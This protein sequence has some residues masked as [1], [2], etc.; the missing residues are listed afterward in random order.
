MS[1][2]NDVEFSLA[3]A[4]TA[5]F[6]V[7]LETD[8]LVPVPVD[9]SGYTA[10]M[11]VLKY[12]GSEFGSQQLALTSGGGGIV[13]GT[14]DGLFT[15]SFTVANTNALATAFGSPPPREPARFRFFV[16]PPSLPEIEI[17]HGSIV[18][19]ESGAVV[20]PVSSS[21]RTGAFTVEA[22][23]SIP[24]G[25][26]QL[27]VPTGQ[28]IDANETLHYGTKPQWYFNGTRTANRSK[29]AG[30]T[31][32]GPIPGKVM[33]FIV[34]GTGA[35]TVAIL[36]GGLSAGT[37]WT[38]PASTKQMVS[39]RDDGVDWVLGGVQEVALG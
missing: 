38:V 9:V 32:V 2:P 11:Q 31:G 10:R 37:I 15:A 5:T 1:E 8:S 30:R 39:V 35:F 3:Y 14:V 18:L 26:E 36:N 23:L 34:G 4:G 27:A 28:M 17:V 33:T 7:T 22:S 19:L 21:V 25:A 20:V 24:F 13:V 12:D 6:T 16:T 29:T